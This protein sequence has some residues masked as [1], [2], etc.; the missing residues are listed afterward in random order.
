MMGSD[1]LCQRHD[2][3]GAEE[4]KGRPGDS[5]AARHMQPGST[6]AN[7]SPAFQNPEN[8]AQCQRGDR[9]T[10]RANTRRWPLAA[11]GFDHSVADR[12]A[13]ERDQCEGCTAKGLQ[14]LEPAR[15]A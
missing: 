8:H 11:H 2:K 10:Q 14:A 13:G 15:W 3:D 7:A 1:G 9:K 12:K 4:R 5:E 6:H